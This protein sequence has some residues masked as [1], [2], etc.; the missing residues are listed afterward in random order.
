MS[1][2]S[3][4]EYKTGHHKLTYYWPLEGGYTD[5]RRLDSINEW[6]RK[7]E[8]ALARKPHDAVCKELADQFPFVVFVEAAAAGVSARYIA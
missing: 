1:I 5:R 6:V 2:L 8:K 4:G 7:N 3:G